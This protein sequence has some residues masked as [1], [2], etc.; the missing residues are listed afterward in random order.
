MRTHIPA[1][2]RCTGTVQIACRVEC[3]DRLTRYSTQHA[4]PGGVGW[5]VAIAMSDAHTRIQVPG[6]HTAGAR[7]E[8][9]ELS[10]T[11]DRECGASRRH[12]H[13]ISHHGL[14]YVQRYLYVVA[15]RAERC[16]TSAVVAGAAQESVLKCRLCSIYIVR[17]TRPDSS[18]LMQHNVLTAVREAEP[19]ES[20]RRMPRP[21]RARDGER[22]K[23]G[24][25]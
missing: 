21:P 4:G 3:C 23:L 12:Q 25:S 24:E 13:Q 19:H 17:Y 16:L 18:H 5:G 8:R 10:E 2:T 11:R 22:K 14:T 20:A 7:P 9:R 6:R 15:D 1:G